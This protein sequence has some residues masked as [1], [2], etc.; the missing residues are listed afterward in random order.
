MIGHIVLL[1]L[2]DE[3]GEELAGVM[4][5][6]ADLQTKMPGMSAFQHGVNH[7]FEHL[8]PDC[9]YGFIAMFEDEVALATYAQDEEHKALGTRLVSLCRG[10]KAGLMVVDLAV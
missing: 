1:S 4:V 5:G 10:G 2:A 8:S 6:L 3:P 7:D 9:D